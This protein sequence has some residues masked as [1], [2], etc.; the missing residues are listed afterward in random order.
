MTGGR[1]R[2]LLGVTRVGGCCLFF[3]KRPAADP[4]LAAWSPH[5][6]EFQVYSLFCHSLTNVFFNRVDVGSTAL[7]TRQKPISKFLEIPQN[8]PRILKQNGTQEEK[9]YS[10]AWTVLM[11]VW[12]P[13]TTTWSAEISESSEASSLLV[14]KTSA[15]NEK[16]YNMG[17]GGKLCPKK[18]LFFF[19][20]TWIE[21]T[22][23]FW[24]VW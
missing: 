5:P 14:S 23:P 2:E 15:T 17:I 19:Y 20:H 18:G 8:G 21:V 22:W 10:F 7:G 1:G 13:E 9:P 11:Q 3:S 12:D 16:S 6:L 4:A 24:K